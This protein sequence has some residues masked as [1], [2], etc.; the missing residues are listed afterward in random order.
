[1]VLVDEEEKCCAKVDRRGSADANAPL[2]L[3]RL[4]ILCL[5]FG[6]PTTVQIVHSGELLIEGQNRC[7]DDSLINVWWDAGGAV[8]GI[9]VYMYISYEL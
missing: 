5:R 8:G 2:R 4:M 3:R 9:F 6:T 1:M 7:E